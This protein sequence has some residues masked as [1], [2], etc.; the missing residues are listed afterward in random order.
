MHT[1]ITDTTRTLFERPHGLSNRAPPTTQNSITFNNKH[2]QTGNTQNIL[3]HN[4][5]LNTTHKVSLIVNCRMSAFFRL[6]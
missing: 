1:G 6:P 5:T 3:E 4:I 2:C